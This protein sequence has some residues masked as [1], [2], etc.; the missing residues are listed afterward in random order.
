VCK[1]MNIQTSIHDTTVMM[2]DLMVC[3]EAI[4]S[5]YSAVVPRRFSSHLSIPLS[6]L[7]T[8]CI[9]KIMRC[10]RANNEPLFLLDRNETYG[11]SLVCKLL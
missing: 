5:F 11:V 6:F 9:D 3:Y 10:R 1:V 8:F 4:A 2:S 7:R